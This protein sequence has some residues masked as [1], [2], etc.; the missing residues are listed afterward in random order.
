M[1]FFIDSL[2]STLDEIGA[3]KPF[4]E[5]VLRL[6]SHMKNRS[7]V[8]YGEYSFKLASYYEGCLTKG[9]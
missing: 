2:C 8:Q 5:I 3:S 6:N 7:A 9:Y 1:S 4:D